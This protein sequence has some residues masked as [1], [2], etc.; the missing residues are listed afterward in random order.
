MIS[1]VLLM[2]LNYF[3]LGGLLISVFSLCMAMLSLYISRKSWLQSNRPIV[4]ARVTTAS[5]GNQGTALNILVENTGNRP[6]K[7]V[8]L[9]IE[10]SI[11]ENFYTENADKNGRRNIERVFAERGIIPILGNGKSVTN[12][13]GF[14]SGGNRQSVWRDDARAEVKISYEDL[15]GRKFTHQNPILIAGD[16]GFAGGFWEK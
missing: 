9:E 15:D 12:S 8:K 6:A 4:T 2:E 10:Q 7:N 11:L 1:E 13:F 5:G 16:E 14:L 3:Q